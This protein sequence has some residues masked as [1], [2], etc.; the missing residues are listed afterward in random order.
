MEH[1]N[2]YGADRTGGNFEQYL[3]ARSGAIQSASP[4]CAWCSLIF[5]PVREAGDCR[6]IKRR[7]DAKDRRSRARRD[8]ASRAMAWL[9][10]PLV[11]PRPGVFSVGMSQGR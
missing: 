9:S 3:D 10:W 11:A 8:G 1:R 2:C 6:G 4:V 5:S 7:E